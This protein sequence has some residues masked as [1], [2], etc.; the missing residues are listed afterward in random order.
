MDFSLVSGSLLAISGIVTLGV[1]IRAFYMYYITQSQRLFTVGLAMAIVAMGIVCSVLN[2]SPLIGSINVQ[3]AWYFATLVGFFFLFAS[4]L[5]KTEEQFTLLKRWEIIAAVVIIAL[6]ALTPVL[7]PFSNPTILLIL[8]V[9]RATV[10]TLGFV[11]Y[12]MLY[13]SKGT[14]FSLLMCL[15]FLF[16]GVSYVILMPQLLSNQWSD[17]SSVSTSVRI[18]GDIIL[19]A[20]FLIG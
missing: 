3:W 4:S 10:C 7:P 6:I 18:V 9:L 14:R 11:R 5:M 15:T 8:D 13:T 12:L 1:S 16:V 2:G 20:A 17:L 19:F